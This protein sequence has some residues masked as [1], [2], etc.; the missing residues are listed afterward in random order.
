MNV[1]KLRIFS[2]LGM[3]LAN[4]EEALLEENE[5]W[6]RAKFLLQHELLN[7]EGGGGLG[8]SCSSGSRLMMVHPLM[9]TPSIH[10]SSLAMGSKQSSKLSRNHPHQ[11][12]G[13]VAINIFDKDDD[14]EDDSLCQDLMDR[15]DPSANNSTHGGPALEKAYTARFRDS[16]ES[17]QTR[18]LLPTDENQRLAT[19]ETELNPLT[20]SEAGPLLLKEREAVATCE[21][22]EEQ[23]GGAGA[24]AEDRPCRYEHLRRPSSELDLVLSPAHVQNF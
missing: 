13:A 15:D 9:M 11:G 1:A 6:E 14:D 22:E 19:E 17:F 2:S 12:A 20:L 7:L 5:V 23:A 18:P 24:L 10:E 16:I 8:S 3:L 21:T 4:E